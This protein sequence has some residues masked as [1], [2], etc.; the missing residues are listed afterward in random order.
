MKLFKLI[1][2]VFCSSVFSNCSK[3][4]SKSDQEIT[5][6]NNK[7]FVNN[8]QFSRNDSTSDYY[9]KASLDGQKISYPV[10]NKTV[11]FYN[12]IGSVTKIN[13]GVLILNDSSQHYFRYFGIINN[14]SNR[15]YNLT[16]TLSS[17][18]SNTI[19]GADS[20]LR[21]YL[22]RKKEMFFAK[23]LSIEA[24]YSSTDTMGFVLSLSTCPCVNATTCVPV[25]TQANGDQ[26]GSYL[27]IKK[28]SKTVTDQYD[29]Y[30][31][32]FQFQC[33]LYMHAVPVYLFRNLSAGELSVQIALPH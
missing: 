7:E 13:N 2:I 6:E 20:I 22:D 14:C 29:L 11:S 8:F 28:V 9:F 10:D 17:P 31:V 33:N 19:R 15:N 24:N 18:L 26:T 5:W 30:D 16:V 12:G 3:Q 1:L 21:L 23:N 32:T 27:I 25:G 4:V